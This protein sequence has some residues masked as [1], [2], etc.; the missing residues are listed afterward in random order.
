MAATA[1]GSIKAHI[2]SLGLGLSAYRDEAPSKASLPYV[3]ITEGITTV[4]VRLGDNGRE[5]AVR[6]LVQI[7][8]WEAWRTSDNRIAE[9]YS[10]ARN[11]AAGLRSWQP[12]DLPY[13]VHS[14]YLQQQVRTLDRE[15]NEVRNLFQVE[16]QRDIN[17]RESE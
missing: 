4:P 10:L 5:D 7:D 12:T 2:E 17:D 14:I 8:L 6:E 15:K 11:L 9:S 3:T 13:R 1:S 16:I